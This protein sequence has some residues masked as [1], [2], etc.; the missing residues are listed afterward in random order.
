ME[1]LIKI[2]P[3]NEK[4][5]SILKMVDITL[6][7]IGQIDNKKFPSNVIKE[8]YETVRELMSIILLLDGFKIVGENAHKRLIEYLKLN[9]KQF[10][11]S[12]ISFIDDLRVLRNKIAYDGFFVEKDYLDRKL[13]D[14]NKIINKLKIIIE[15]KK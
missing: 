8:Y 7:M 4:A 15:K 12:E 3:N 5:R 6:E 1:D 9:Y 13:E 2:T 14:I 10:G 11:G